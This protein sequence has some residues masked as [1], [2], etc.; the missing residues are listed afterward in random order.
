MNTRQ[1]LSVGIDIG[2]TTT[3]VIF[4]RLELVNRAAV[5]QVPR[6]EFIKRDI[7]WQSPVFFTPVDK[8]GGLKEAE[9]KALILAQYQ[10]AGIAPESVDSGAIIITGESAKT[11]N[12]RPAVMTLSQ[13]LGDFVVASAG[14]HLESVIAG[15]GAGAQSLS[16]QRMC[17]VLNIDIGGGTSNYALFDAGKVSGTA[18][19]NVGGRLLETDAQGRVVYAH[20]PGQMIID[21]VFGSGTDARALAAAQLG[22]VARR[23]ADLIVE[24][25]TGALSP[26]AQSLMQTGLLPA[27]I[28]PEVITLSGGVGEC[29]RHQPAD[30]FCFSDIGPLLATAL[31]EHPRLR[32]MNVQFPAQTDAYV[33]ALPATLPVRY[34]ALLT[35]INALTAFV[36]RYPNP[37]P[38]LV[39]AE[40]DFG[41]ALGMLLRPQL[42]QLPLAVI[43]EVVVRAGDYIDIGTPLFGGSVVPVTVKS[44]AFPS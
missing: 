40:Q 3:Q 10:A 41:K 33:L 42:P 12:A 30:P 19:L 24:V 21:E 8:Q 2:T 16:E 35:V 34:A 32:E 9:L 26:L 17:R 28:T 4:S 38:L 44:L 36:A 15:H 39:V 31:H 23:M 18:C 5:S 25:I 7:S 43:D 13:S 37:H 22:Q 1:L 6:Y 29:Y 20:Q 27:D 11:R 14:P